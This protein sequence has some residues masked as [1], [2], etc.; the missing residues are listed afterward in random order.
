MK[1][2]YQEKTL[3]L[4]ELWSVSGEVIDGLSIELVDVAGDSQATLGIS[5][6]AIIYHGRR[7]SS[8]GSRYTMPRASVGYGEDSVGHWDFTDTMFNGFYILCHHI[9]VHAK[10][11]TLGVYGYDC[12][13]PKR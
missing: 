11:V 13:K 4:G 7:V 12:W 8:A 1:I 3:T 10:T 9:N 5:A 2:D 6:F